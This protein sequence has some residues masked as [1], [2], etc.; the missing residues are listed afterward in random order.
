MTDSS[1]TVASRRTILVAAALLSATAVSALA[2]AAS[3]GACLVQDPVH[4][5]IATHV[6]T[7]NA[8]DLAAKNCE[9]NID[10]FRSLEEQTV[11]SNA[12]YRACRASIAASMTVAKIVPTTE[13]GHQALAE[14]LRIARYREEVANGH[15]LN[16]HASRTGERFAVDVE[17]VDAA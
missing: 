10:G 12:A 15:R 5:A 17:L 11:V 7:L 4:A 1:L 8:F 3:P 13:A 6:S 9:L 2:I 14:H 16:D